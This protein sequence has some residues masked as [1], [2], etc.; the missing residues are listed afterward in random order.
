[1]LLLSPASSTIE[2]AL[3]ILRGGGVVVHATETCYGIACDLSNPA[4]VA[5]L[6]AI[7]KRPAAQ[8]VSGLFASVEDAKRYVQWTG[9]ADAHARK[10]LPGPLTLILPLRGDAPCA[11]FPTL[12][13]TLTL[14]IRISSHPL[15]QELVAR[16]GRPISTTSANIH[17]EANPYDA[18]AIFERFKREK[19]QPDL[20]IDSGTLPPTPPSTVIDLTKDGEVLRRG[21]I[22]R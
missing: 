15:A 14:G 5:T 21:D 9:E 11:L 7:K 2:K 1:M 8:P 17:G 18:R 20:I 13:P 16:F 10:H 4:A 22:Q 12:T 19:E 3:E 6:F